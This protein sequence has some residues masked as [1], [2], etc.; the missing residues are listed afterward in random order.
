MITFLIE[1]VEHIF[2]KFHFEFVIDSYQV[3]VL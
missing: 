2:Y 3:S 1:I